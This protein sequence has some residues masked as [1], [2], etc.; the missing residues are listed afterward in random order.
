MHDY[1]DYHE[2]V[3]KLGDF[4]N[5]RIRNIEDGINVLFEVDGERFL[6]VRYY[7]K[8]N[9]IQLVFY[10]FY[11]QGDGDFKYPLSE[12]KTESE[13]NSMLEALKIPILE[14]KNE[15][16][17]KYRKQIRKIETDLSRLTP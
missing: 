1:H 17:R 5:A 10:S 8:D 9:S 16:L 7:P 13:F 3:E 4:L 6:I 14:G 15:I 12:L 11:L 2:F